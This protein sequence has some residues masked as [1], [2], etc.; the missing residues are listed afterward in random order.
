VNDGGPGIDAVG[1]DESYSGRSTGLGLSIAR[2]T[3]EKVGGS[4]EVTTSHLGGAS[5]VIRL[6]QL[7]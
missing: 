4:I 7:T 1:E 2:T 3:A 6:P 5:V